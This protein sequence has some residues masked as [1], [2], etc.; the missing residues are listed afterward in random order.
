MG[1]NINK[2]KHCELGAQLIQ[3]NLLNGNEIFYCSS[4]VNK[5]M[6]FREGV[7]ILFTQFGYLGILKKHGFIR[8]KKWNLIYYK[9]YNSI[10]NVK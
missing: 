8:E 10:E 3:E 6:P 7:P 2:L 1:K 5:E 4:L 9:N